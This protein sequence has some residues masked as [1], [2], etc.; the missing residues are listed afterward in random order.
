MMLG[1]LIQAW[2]KQRRLTLQ[3]AARRLGVEYTALWRFEQ[4]RPVGER[5]WVRIM[6]WLLTAPKQTKG[7]K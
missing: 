6:V 3:Q 2:R 7:K 4:G 1:E 5:Y